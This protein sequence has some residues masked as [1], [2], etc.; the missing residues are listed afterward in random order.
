MRVADIKIDKDHTL[1]L[2][3]EAD[4][5]AKVDAMFAGVE[6]LRTACQTLVTLLDAEDWLAALHL[7]VTQAR[8]ALKETK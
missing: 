1:T 7:A 4:Q 2:Y 5:T 3:C 6:R 8:A